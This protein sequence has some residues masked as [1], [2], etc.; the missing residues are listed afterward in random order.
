MSFEIE[1]KY[2]DSITTQIEILI[3]EL[4]QK[5]KNNN[6]VNNLDKI[7]IPVGICLDSGLFKSQLIGCIKKNISY[8]SEDK[9]FIF[10]A[11]LC[12]SKISNNELKREDF[13]TFIT[14][15]NDMIDYLNP[16]ETYSNEK[17]TIF[18]TRGIPSLTI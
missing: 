16:M 13:Q 6:I 5:Y 1:K 15:I 12:I 18:T 17:S 7:L 10:F 3:D 4:K 9:I 11:E 2:E 8:V 14:E